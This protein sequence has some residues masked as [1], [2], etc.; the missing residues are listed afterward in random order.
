MLQYIF[1]FLGN[2]IEEISDFNAYCYPENSQIV[3]DK[4]F[5]KNLFLGYNSDK[6]SQRGDN[7][8]VQYCIS[9]PKPQ[10]IQNSQN[11][12]LNVLSA[13]I[14]QNV[15]VGLIFEEEDN[16]FDYHQIFL[17][18][19][20][21]YLNC[22]YNSE[23]FHSFKEETDVESLLITLFIDLR[24][25]GDEVIEK[26][27]EMDLRS[28][29]PVIKLFLFGLDAS[30]KTSLVRRIKTDEYSDNFFTPTKKFN[31]EYVE[32]QDRGLLSIWDM[33]GQRA[34]RK[35]WLLGLQ[36]SNVIAF[37]ID[38]ANP[39][40]FE[41]SKIGFWN[42]LNRYELHGV[43]L[44]ILANKIDLINDM[45]KEGKKAH[46]NQVKGEMSDF[47]ELDKLNNREWKFLFTSVKTNHNIKTFINL[48]HELTL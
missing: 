10:I 18:L 20:N 48:I 9:K 12:G 32:D 36:D 40:R 25:F 11:T 34:F 22:N 30:G 26:Y 44:I 15:H 6:A 7:Q 16:P 46:L 23:S 43:P 29:T 14:N 1:C 3:K 2:H 39:K 8:P 19:L 27:P 28:F 38:V 21:E 47:F 24:R 31:I 41:E 45:R 37:M 17:E 13:N 4:Q 5:I 35:K 42:I 33:P